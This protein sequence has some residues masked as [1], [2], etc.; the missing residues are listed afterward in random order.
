MFP[1]ACRSSTGFTAQGLKA[2]WSTQQKKRENL[3]FRKKNVR[4]Q[5]CVEVCP[6]ARSRFKYK[7]LHNWHMH[8]ESRKGSQP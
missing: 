5:K 3:P 7:N 4:K 8:S 6:S 2:S 1:V